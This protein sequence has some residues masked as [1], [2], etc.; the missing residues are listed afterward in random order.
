MTG[1][2]NWVHAVEFHVNCVKYHKGRVLLRWI[3]AE[4]LFSFT[5][6]ADVMFLVQKAAVPYSRWWA[7]CAQG[8][9]S[10]IHNSARM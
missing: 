8:L 1:G 6:L 7:V 5:H 9:Q 2:N 3:W 4:I 10:Q